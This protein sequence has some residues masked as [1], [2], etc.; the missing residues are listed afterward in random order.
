VQN[1]TLANG[2]GTRMTESEY[3]NIP[4]INPMLILPY[5]FHVVLGMKMSISA[6]QILSSHDEKDSLAVTILRPCE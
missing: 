3:M 5:M 2:V 6:C 1:V 4:H